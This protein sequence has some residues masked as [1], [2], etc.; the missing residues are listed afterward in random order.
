MRMANLPSAALL[1]N[2]LLGA[3]FL[4][5]VA[6]AAT[7]PKV[8]IGE[9]TQTI[10]SGLGSEAT[11]GVKRGTLGVAVAIEFSVPD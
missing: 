6:T 9:T 5:L 10:S 4:R 3:Y 7:P 11:L 1:R 8:R 2:E